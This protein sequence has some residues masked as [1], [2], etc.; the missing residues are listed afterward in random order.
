MKAD[1]LK[2][3]TK[4]FAHACVKLAATFPDTALGRIVR[5]QLL[6]RSAVEPLLNEALELTRIFAASRKTSSQPR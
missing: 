4:A 5:G 2:D 6:P 3:R 1:E